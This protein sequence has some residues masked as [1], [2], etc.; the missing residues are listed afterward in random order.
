M[1]VDNETEVV[2]GIEDWF[3]VIDLSVI[4]SHTHEWKYLILQLSM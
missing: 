4:L 2:Q 3:K 1:I